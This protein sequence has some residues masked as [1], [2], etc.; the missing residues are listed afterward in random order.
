MA[1]TIEELQVLIT[2][3]TAGLRHELQ[4][5]KKQLH[6]TQKDVHRV[7]SS[8]A[9]SFNKLATVA[10]IAAIGV[11]LKSA[12]KEAMTFEASL[13]QVNRMMGQS[14]QAFKQWADESASAWGMGRA[15]AMKYGA[16]Y[17]NLI[18]GF[19][20]STAETAKYTQDLL[21]TS[22]II[23]SST[24]RTMSDT[25]ER[26]RSGLLGNTEA[27]EDL[28][29]NVNIAMIEST[30]AFKKFANGQSWAKL[31]F[32]TQQQ[33]RLFAILEQAATKYGIEIANNT[34][35]RHQQFVAQLKNVQ[36]S[37]G[38]AFLPI[39]NAVLPAL[40]VLAQALASIMQTVAQFMQALFGVSAQ[41]GAQAVQAQTGAV[42]KLGNAYDK[43]GKK[44][45]ASA[46]MVAGFDEVNGLSEADKATGGGDAGGASPSGIGASAIP[47]PVIPKMDTDAIPKQIQE[48]ADKVKQ[49]LATVF[50]PIKKSWDTYAPALTAAFNQAKDSWAN[51][52]RDTTGTMS[53]IWQNGGAQV[54]EHMTSLVLALGLLALR[55]HNEFIA[56]IISW[57][58]NALNPQTNAA[59]QGIINIVNALLASMVEFVTYLSGDGFG[60]VQI[61]LGALAGALA[62]L[63][64]YKTVMGIIGF[65]KELG[66]TVKALF[67][68]L[69]AH[70]IMAVV[71]AIGALVGAL[72]TAYNTNEDFRKTVD[73]LWGKLKNSLMPV[74]ESVKQVCIALWNDVLVPFGAFLKDVFVSSWDDV[75]Q[76]AKL[77]WNNVLVPFGEFLKFL[78]MEVL[79]PLG[80]FLTDV[81]VASW[82]ANIQ[83]AKLLWNEILVPFGEFLKLLWNEVL[84]PLG[85]FLA[86]MFVASWDAVIQVAKFLWNEILVPFGEFLQWL[87]E[88]V[89]K[90]VASVLSDVLAVAFKA[91]IEVAKML[92]KHVLVPLGNFMSFVWNKIISAVI[93]ILVH[94]W[95]NVLKPIAEFLGKIFQ[96]VIKAL[97]AVFQFLWQNVLK[98][99][100]TFLT[101]V[102]LAA[103]EHVSK[104]VGGIMG[105]IKKIFEGLIDFIVG[106]FTGDWKKAWEGVKKIFSGVFESLWGIVKVPL[107]LI[108]DGINWLIDG[109]NSLDFK[110]PEWD[111]L[112]KYAGQ[113]FG[114]DI[115]HIPP[116]ARGGIVDSPTLAM[117]GEAGKEAV[118]PLENTSFVNTLASAI[119]SSVLAAQQMANSS[120]P[121][122]SGGGDIVVQLDG[123][124]LARVINPYLSQE[125]HRIGSTILKPI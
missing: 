100:V 32:Q 95:N 94:W 60:Y 98:P 40:T 113:S 52:W 73:E 117:I 54:V 119:G 125:Q 4:K 34:A 106:I 43:T 17:A 118:V 75:V 62:G 121:A 108:I 64:V 58:V 49:I 114:I 6:D 56:P 84:V 85:A 46:G 97:I 29:V 9:A 68:M 80:A 93:E 88:N 19:T 66:T 69:A 96:P 1:T 123:V 107:N 105:G 44:A 79:V 25:M 45:K 116:L 70:P 39:Y 65:V 78:W 71:V 91:V 92:W 103:F 2:G 112:G 55:I 74:F 101:A 122:S 115:P 61:A 50:E 86:D 13:Q 111:I 33:I 30:N 38:Q 57:F 104:S 51:I 21:Q 22:A 59:M 63:I 41:A 87:W 24:G 76:I 42:N 10:G 31:D 67:A 26:I 120:Q 18:S 16:V 124:T 82:E 81:F 110:L 5:L 99:L 90:P 77:L 15:E 20:K 83:V 48:M 11:A 3:Q 72:I 8:I 102:F 23:A 53:G 47:T 7:T 27:I 12:T 35:S 109:L 89:L 36:L 28:G 14:A 37:L